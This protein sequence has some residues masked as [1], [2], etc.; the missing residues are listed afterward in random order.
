MP[1]PVRRRPA[2][3]TVVAAC[4]LA[5]S[6]AC[7]SSSADRAGPTA[8]V[9]TEP[10][11]TTTTNPYA[12]PAV[13][14]AAYVNRVLAGLDAALGD[15]VRTV[16]NAH[17]IPPEAYDR[18]KAIY[19]DPDRL[20]RAIDGLQRDIRNRFAGYKAVPGNAKTV[21]TQLVTTK[22]NCI[23]ARVDRDYS[24]VGTNTLP[25]I[26]VQWI[27]LTLVDRIRDPQRLN[28]TPWAFIYD[29]FQSDHSQPPDPC[30]N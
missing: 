24:A 23:F 9:A 16:H 14:D 28:P 3:R 13:I 2:I 27:G 11:Q 6:A 21:A 10:P 22:P 8:T 30:A 12:V 7:S 25:G 20:Q 29:G 26:A 17:A 1:F 18:M 4:L 5:A 19:A 15:V